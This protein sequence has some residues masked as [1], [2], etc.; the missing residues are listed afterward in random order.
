MGYAGW[1]KSSSS[2][3]PVCTYRTGKLGTGWT[4]RTNTGQVLD[5]MY[6][7]LDQMYQWLDQMYQWLEHVSIIRSDVLII[8]FDVSVRKRLIEVTDYLSNQS[9][10]STMVNPFR[11]NVLF[12]LM[13]TFVVM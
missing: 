5:L 1:Q 10:V 12:S 2:L 11:L 13:R 4:T 8:G 7:W 3:V 6:Q 9:L